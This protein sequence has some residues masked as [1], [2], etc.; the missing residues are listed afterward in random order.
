MARGDPPGLFLD[1]SHEGGITSDPRERRLRIDK[2]SDARWD[3][4]LEIP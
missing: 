1:G 3:E 4:P 2:C